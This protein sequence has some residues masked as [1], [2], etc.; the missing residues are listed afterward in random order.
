MSYRPE[1]R[2]PLIAAAM[3]GMLAGGLAV[4][5][6]GGKANIGYAGDSKGHLVTDNFGRCVRTGS[7]T[8]ELALPE[9]EGG[10]PKPA[11][12]PAPKPEPVAVP[13]PAPAPVPVVETKTITL[14]A[15]AL[16]DVNSSTLK[17]AGQQSLDD[18]ATRLKGLTSLEAITITG[19]TDN[20]GA[21]AYNQ[22]LSERRA[23]AVKDYLVSKGVDAGKIS[24]AGEGAN[25]PVADNGNADGRAKNRRVEIE[26]RGVR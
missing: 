26:V 10:A 21:A 23:Q 9:C 12:A 25:R 24:A 8:P 17:P 2:L 1:T 4:A 5:H 20:S 15:G 18:M 14:G 13:P 3:A 16:F 7:W 19:H 6:T 11:V 22:S